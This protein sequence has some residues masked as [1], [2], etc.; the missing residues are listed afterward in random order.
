MPLQSRDVKPITP[1]EVPGPD[2]PSK[3]IAAFNTLIAQNFYKGHAVVMQKE[4][5][6][7]LVKEG[8]NRDQLF[9]NHWLDVEPIFEKA[10]WHVEYDKPGYNETYEPSFEFRRKRSH[11]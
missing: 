4:V 1:D 8:M 5:V 7:L 6:E 2:I 11:D 10:G 9:E 3:V